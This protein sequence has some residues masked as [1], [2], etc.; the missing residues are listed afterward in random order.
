MKHFHISFHRM[1]IGLG[2]YDP[3]GRCSE[4]I[5]L[6]TMALVRRPVGGD[7]PC[8]NNTGK[9]PFTTTCRKRSFSHRSRQKLK[10]WS[11]HGSC[12]FR[13]ACKTCNTAHPVRKTAAATRNT[14]TSANA[15]LKEQETKTKE[16]KVVNSCG[17]AE[18]AVR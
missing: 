3:A 6:Q 11:M 2:I 15:F 9:G 10:Q 16:G 5:T 1:R 12:R 14:H 4:D 17:R 8:L 7:S 13:H 18:G